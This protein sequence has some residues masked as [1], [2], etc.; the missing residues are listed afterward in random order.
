MSTII[1][2]HLKPCGSNWVKIKIKGA[3][4]KI[5]LHSLIDH[6]MLIKNGTRTMMIRCVLAELLECKFHENAYVS[7]CQHFFGTLC[8]NSF[9]I[10]HQITMVL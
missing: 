10:K 9:V 3:E 7:L 4:L 2:E 1:S 8:C 5:N 6:R